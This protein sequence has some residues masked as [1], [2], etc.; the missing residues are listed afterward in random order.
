MDLRCSDDVTVAVANQSLTH[1]SLPCYL[2]SSGAMFEA[3]VAGLRPRG[4]RTVAARVEERGMV[5][6]LISFL[7]V[8]LLAGWIAGRLTKGSGFGLLGNLGLGVVGAFI[9]GLLFW[10]L[11]LTAHNLIGQIV[12]AVIGAIVL[13]YVAAKLKSRAA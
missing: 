8:G 12:T 11:G 4:K 1:D 13:L 5:G 10:V 7:V 3:S 6:G 9:G 2:R